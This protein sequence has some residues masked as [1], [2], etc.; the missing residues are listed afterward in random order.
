MTNRAV[1]ATIRTPA[2]EPRGRVMVVAELNR[3][4]ADSIDLH[5]QIKV[6]H[7]NVKGPHFAALH[8]LF[9][10]FAVALAGRIDQI[11]ERAVTLGGVAEGTLP[12]VVQRSALA[13]ADTT[14]RDGIAHARQL[15]ERFAV[16]VDGLQASRR[17]AEAAGD[18]DTADLLTQVIGEF[19]KF[20]WFLTATVE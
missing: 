8:P 12:A 17:A 3:R 10:Q 6:A 14:V 11:A 9:E 15:V 20:A 19:E 1:A 4:L 5:A 16:Y 2:S 13:A 18:A 7:W